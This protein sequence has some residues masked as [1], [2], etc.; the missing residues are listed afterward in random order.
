M[1]DLRTAKPQRAL[2]A[3]FMAAA[4][5]TFPCGDAIAKHLSAQHAPLFLAW[6]RYTAG[7]AFV[8]PALLL[9]GRG[10]HVP[11]VARGHVP[12][13]ALRAAFAVGAVSL[14]YLAIARIPLADALGA[15]FVAPVLAALL[16]A[17]VLGEALGP[18]RLLAVGV[19]F[20]GALLVAR[21]GVTMG[22]GMAYALGA[23]GCFACYMVATRARAQSGSPLATLA[24]QYV[25]GGLLLLVP[26]LLDWSVPTVATWLLILLMGLVS[27]ISHLLVIAAFRLAEA[28]L[29]A[30]L[31][32]LELLGGT[33]LG[34]LVFGQLPAPVTWLGIALIVAGGLVLVERRPQPGV[35]GRGGG[36]E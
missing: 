21:P 29:L 4:M 18:R 14:Y 12:I 5:L 27:A 2:G 3:A 10:T 25:A 24:F 19:G 30:P 31:V 36:T 6:A 9:A 11:G 7:A 23:G 15:Y 16:S 26:A 32:Y 20:A 35:G 1:R 17:A 13:Q 22:A 8:V 34:L 28:S 33:L